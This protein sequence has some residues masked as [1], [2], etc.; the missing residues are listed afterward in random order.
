[1]VRFKKLSFSLLNE[2]LNEGGEQLE[3]NNQDIAQNIL[4]DLQDHDEQNDVQ[5]EIDI[6]RNIYYITNKI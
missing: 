6:Q 2:Q 1:M 3:V 4:A 5:V